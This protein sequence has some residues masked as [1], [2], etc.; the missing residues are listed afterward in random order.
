MSTEN[1]KS[2]A[3]SMFGVFGKKAEDIKVKDES[4]GGG[5][6]FFNPDAKSAPNKIYRAVIKFLPKLYDLENPNKTET[7]ETISYWVPEGQAG[8]RYTS[9]K[10]IGKM[11]KC[12]VAD[13]FWEWKGSGDARLEALTKKLGYKRQFFALIQVV[14]DQAK[15]ENNGKIFL[16]DVPYSIQKK[17]HE[18]MYPTKE[19][20]KMGAVANNIFDPLDGWPL[21]MKVGIKDTGEGEYRDYDSCSFND[22]LSTRMI[23]D[24]TKEPLVPADK[25][26]NEEEL[27]AYQNAA[28]E[29]ILAGPSLADVEYK[30]LTEELIARTK[31]ALAALEAGNTGTSTEEKPAEKAETKAET[32]TVAEK[33]ETVK[34]TA[35]TSADDLV[36]QVMGNKSE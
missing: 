22:K 6:N 26:A 29:A 18:V 3:E 23:V 30:P 8:Y 2:I 36:N 1:A 35:T 10:S 15:P 32:S 13:K 4:T 28:L 19:D 31:K 25:P 9:P 33:T 7:V 5:S 17:I 34:E 12:P 16:Y 11:E 20:I 21:V 14:E 27:M 24:F